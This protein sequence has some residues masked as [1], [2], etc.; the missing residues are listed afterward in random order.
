MFARARDPRSFR[1]RNLSAAKPGTVRGSLARANIGG[2][3][4]VSLM[5][6]ESFLEGNA[7]LANAGAVEDNQTGGSGSIAGPDR[8]SQVSLAEC[9]CSTWRPLAPSSRHKN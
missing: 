1:A 5:N 7:A 4:L 3:G 2:S 6:V 9:C 8:S